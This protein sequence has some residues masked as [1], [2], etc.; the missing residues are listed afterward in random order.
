MRTAQCT[1]VSSC[2]V[3]LCGGYCGL[4]GS[5]CV[6]W[7]GYHGDRSYKGLRGL[8]GP[9]RH[10]APRHSGVPARNCKVWYSRVQSI[11][12]TTAYSVAPKLGQTTAFA[13]SM[14][15]TTPSRKGLDGEG[16][17]KELSGRQNQRTLI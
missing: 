16:F 8:W 12:S 11:P 17:P 3:S 6:V 2:S 5:K 15:M 4:G 7:H 14:V 13:A 9:T 10:T 1:Q